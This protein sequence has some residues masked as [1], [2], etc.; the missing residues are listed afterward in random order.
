[1]YIFFGEHLILV[2]EF[3]PCVA[4]H[5]WISLNLEFHRIKRKNK[6]NREITEITAPSDR[7]HLN[8]L[9]NCWQQVPSDSQFVSLY[10]KNTA[11]AKKSK[12]YWYLHSVLVQY[13]FIYYSIIVIFIKN[14]TKM[15]ILV[16]SRT[17]NIV[18]V[19][20]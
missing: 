17:Q 11:L 2:H 16:L 10:F 13:I 5:L 8:W 3:W 20:D 1:M 6:K 19:Q 4:P 9:S 7:S 14:S 15:L 12:V 18:E